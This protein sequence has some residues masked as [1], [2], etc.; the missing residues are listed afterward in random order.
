MG[1][2]GDQHAVR[3]RHDVDRRL[4]LGEPDRLGAV[5]NG[6]I[7]IVLRA[8]DRGAVDQRLRQRRIEPDRLVDVGERAIEIAERFLRD[9]A[10][11][12]RE[13]RSR[14]G[15]D[16]HVVVGDRLGVI[17][18]AAPGI[19]AVVEDDAIRRPELQCV[20]EIGDRDVVVALVVI[21]RA[22]E[23]VDR[24]ARLQP[25]CF[26]GVRNDFCVVALL[27][28]AHRAPEIDGRELLAPEHLQRDDLAAGLDHPVRR[29]GLGGAEQP[30]L[31]ARLGGCGRGPQGCS[32]QGERDEQAAHGGDSLRRSGCLLSGGTLGFTCGSS[33]VGKAGS[34]IPRVGRIC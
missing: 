16:R 29:R 25:D 6:A 3:R 22:P 17:A 31:A 2:G 19:A 34:G 12:E 9:A 28:P 24:L 11:L 1:V 33:D 30:E 8:P 20:V 18:L 23:I 27:V 21:G 26:G 7:E 10:V 5:G 4:V 32:E 15:L 14:I 13:R